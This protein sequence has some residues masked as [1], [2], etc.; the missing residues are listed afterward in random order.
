MF[1]YF[2]IIN[3]NHFF[4]FSTTKKQISF[5]YLIEQI[6]IVIKKYYDKNCKLILLGDGAKWISNLAKKIKAKYILCRFHLFQK[7]NAIFN[8][9]AELKYGLEQLKSKENL[10]LKL[11]FNN[12]MH[13]KKYDELINF[14]YS[15]KSIIKKYLGL[16]RSNLL[17]SLC[18]Y[19]NN[20]FY[21]LTEIDD[22]NIDFFIN[23]NAEAFISHLIKKPIKNVWNNI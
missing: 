8:N 4:I 14:I 13:N 11:I 6:N 2:I 21:G 9:S 12:F 22:K 18:K 20:N 23:N 17:F 1:L 5:A 7:I 19:I 15:N 10:D 16:N 3:K